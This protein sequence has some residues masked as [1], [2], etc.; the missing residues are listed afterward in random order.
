MIADQIT[1]SAGDVGGSDL[2]EFGC[3]KRIQPPVQAA[4]KIET[5]CLNGEYKSYDFGK[6]EPGELTITIAYAIA[7]ATFVASLFKQRKQ[8]QIDYP[9]D[10][11]QAIIGTLYSTGIDPIERSGEVTQTFIVQVEGDATPQS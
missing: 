4:E 5:T 8:Y 6:I 9:D 1:I 3:I 2:T 11:A 10:S 7:N